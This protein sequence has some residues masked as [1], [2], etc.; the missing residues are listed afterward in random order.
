[1][2][3]I[4]VATRLLNDFL[5]DGLVSM[6][7]R[8]TIQKARNFAAAR[9]RIRAALCEAQLDEFDWLVTKKKHAIDDPVWV[10]QHRVRLKAAAEV[11]P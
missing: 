3:E 11:R 9:E 5:V 8:T 7:G 1:M 10:E 2:N 4:S 6:N